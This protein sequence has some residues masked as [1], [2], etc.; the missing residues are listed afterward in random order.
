MPLPGYFLGI[1]FNDYI[2]AFDHWI[3]FGLLLFLGEKMIKEALSHDEMPPDASY[4]FPKYQYTALILSSCLL[5]CL[6]KLL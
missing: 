3:A 6:L 5:T 2:T 1:S 4:A